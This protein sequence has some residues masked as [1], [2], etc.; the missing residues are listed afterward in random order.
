MPFVRL[1][2]PF[3]LMFFGGVGVFLGAVVC[4]NSVSKGSIV[5][6][7]GAGPDLTTTTI[8]RADDPNGYWTT[9]ALMGFLPL[10]SGLVSVAVGR[11]MLRK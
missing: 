8:S 4:L 5:Y 11:R 10:A 6:S 9:L 3:G 2:V 7:T 1:I